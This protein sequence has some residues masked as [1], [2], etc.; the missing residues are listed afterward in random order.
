MRLRFPKFGILDGLAASLLVFAASWY[1]VTPDFVERSVDPLVYDPASNSYASLR[2]IREKNTARL[3]TRN[4]DVFELL[5]SVELIAWSD[6]HHYAKPQRTGR[7]VEYQ[8]PEPDAG[9]VAANGFVELV[10]RWEYHFGGSAQA[11]N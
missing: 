3:F 5:D 10:S 11:A 6:L 4:R 8:M 1:Y 2:C 9:C 7:L